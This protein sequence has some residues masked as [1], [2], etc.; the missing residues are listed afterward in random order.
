MK[1]TVISEKEWEYAD[2]I[3]KAKM[4]MDPELAKAHLYASVAHSAAGQTRKYTGEPYMVHP[5]AVAQLL[6]WYGATND[7]LAAA[8]LHD[9]V[10]DTEVTEDH[11]S[12]HFNPGI[13]KLVMEVTE[14]DD[15]EHWG[16]PGRPDRATRRALEAKRRTTISGHGQDISCADSMSNACDVVDVAK[17]DYARTY[18]TELKART[19]GLTEASWKIRNAALVMFDEQ[20]ARLEPVADAA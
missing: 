20:L 17:A 11:L 5:Y 14:P 19:K 1:N 3:L 16:R 2:V 12:A 4:A 6:C 10:E 7:Q 15:K 9:V 8:F 18:L 13:V